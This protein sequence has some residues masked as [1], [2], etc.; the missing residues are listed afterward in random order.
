[1]AHLTY[2]D[3]PKA[4]EIY[5]KQC[6]YSQAVRIGDRIECSGQG[7]WDVETCEISSD[8]LTEIDQAF[9][10]VETNLKAAGGTGWNQ[11]NN[12]KPPTARS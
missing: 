6:H 11:E 12:G 4:G 3:Y 7:G 1:M 8:L 2:T 9:S 5:G 10:N